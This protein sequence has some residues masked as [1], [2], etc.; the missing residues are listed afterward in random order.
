MKEKYVCLF[1]AVLYII[2]EHH[3][4]KNS[5]TDLLISSD[6]SAFNYSFITIAAEC[7]E[8]KFIMITKI[9]ADVSSL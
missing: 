6:V 3:F 2:S 9:I 5:W 8:M 1:I 4:Q 7:Q